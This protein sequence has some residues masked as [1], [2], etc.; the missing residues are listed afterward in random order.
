MEGYLTIPP[1]RGTI[2]GRALWK[3]RY[4]VIGGL[5]RDTKQKTG[6]RLGRAKDTSGRALR[7]KPSSLVD[8]ASSTFLSIYK[9]K[10]DSEPVQQY[11][12]ATIAECHVQ[13][14]AHRKQGPILPTLTIQILPDPAADKLRKR[15]SSRTAGLTSS[16]ESGPT[17][18]WFRLAAEDP[19]L[20][21]TEWARYL[22]SFVQ[23][24]MPDRYP[25]SPISPTSPSFINPFSPATRSSM[26]ARP[27]GSARPMHTSYSS[28]SPSLRSRR[29]DISSSHNSSSTQNASNTH[30]YTPVYPSDIPSP[31]T[32]VVDYPDEFIEGWTSAQGRSSTL[33][34]PIRTRASMGPSQSM[35]PVGADSNSPPGARETILDRAFSMRCIPGADTSVPGEEKLSSLARFEA[36]MRE[37]EDRRDTRQRDSATIRE[38]PQSTWDD[39][40]SDADSMAG[41]Q[42]P[43]EDS[44]GD[45]FAHE[46]DHATYSPIAPHSR[47]PAYATHRHSLNHA[48]RSR[49]VSRSSLSF[50]EAQLAENPSILRPHTAHPRNRPPMSP[51]SS[52]HTPSSASPL[53]VTIP[54]HATPKM[55]DIQSAR[56]HAETRDSTSS[57]KRL[58]LNDFSKRLSSSSSLLIVQSNV[59]GGS[60]SNHGDN[61][62]ESHPTS[63]R[64]GTHARGT[65]NERDANCQKSW[66]GSRVFGN[67]EGGFL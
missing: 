51:R 45:N 64:I 49:H 5:Q 29:S 38:A 18:L 4:V 36:L 37:A 7:E 66:R 25:I 12:L 22:Q 13:M 67:S 1:D 59:S 53:H 11:S 61:E 19:A 60:N 62:V 57:V 56:P 30:D 8:Q 31:A 2:L 65:P 42:I 33:G 20:S 52:T 28:D 63:P 40:E 21:L 15:R 47:V 9:S 43:E 48:S 16:K 10:D 39:D 54:N 35:L 34:S 3:T 46:M 14:L 58:S 6:D 44:D 26:H 24:G 27:A 41:D 23:P 17:T 50:H 55:P 32:T